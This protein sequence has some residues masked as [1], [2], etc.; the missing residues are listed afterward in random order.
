MTRTFCCS[1]M[2][3]LAGIFSNACTLFD[4]RVDMK[5]VLVSKPTSQ[6]RFTIRVDAPGIAEARLVID[7]IELSGRVTVGASIPL[8]LSSWG[9]GSHR[10]EAR[11]YDGESRRDS[12]T[13]VLVVDRTPPTATAAPAPGDAYV[14]PGQPFIVELTFSDEIEPATVTPAAV[15][16]TQSN[17]A[18]PVPVT[19]SLS[20]D[21]RHLRIEG[22][23]LADLQAVDL[24][25]SVTNAAGLDGSMGFS[26]NYR[27]VDVTLL[28]PG[29]SSSPMEYAGVI[30][31]VATWWNPGQV[32]SVEVLVDGSPIGSMEA[33]VPF[34]WDTNSVA[35]GTHQITF[36][37]DG[38]ASRP[39]DLFVRNLGPLL[40]SC[41]PN[42]A[43]GLDPAGAADF[44]IA[45]DQPVCLGEASGGV[46]TGP[47]AGIGIA[48]RAGS[49]NFID[50]YSSIWSWSPGAASSGTHTVSFASARN[51]TG[52][53]PRGVVECTMTVPKWRAPFGDT[54][55]AQLDGAD[56]VL[57]DWEGNGYFGLSGISLVRI[58]PGG[59]STPGA[60]EVWR[61]SLDANWWQD[62]SA[63]NGEPFLPA[64]Q[65]R[66]SK[67]TATWIE[68]QPDGGGRIRSAKI[69]W[70]DN[71]LQPAGTLLTF[72]AAAGPVEL[73]ASG[74]AWSQPGTAGARTLFVAVGFGLIADWFIVPV[75]VDSLAD[76]SQGWYHPQGYVTYIETPSGGVGQL[77]VRKLTGRIPAG[78]NSLGDVLNRD[79]RTEPSEPSV[80]LA[81]LQGTL[82]PVVTWVEGGQVLVRTWMEPGGW[83]PARML[84]TDPGKVA[85]SPRAFED[86][87]GGAHLLFV[88]RGV[89][90]DRIEFRSFD[91]T[92]WSVDDSLHP[93]GDV[94]EVS[95]AIISNQTAV[96]WRNPAGTARLRVSRW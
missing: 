29:P 8:D 93:F 78:W 27:P 75:N 26:W 94:S 3:S 53:A 23:P 1:L 13:L 61:N 77:R 7:D 22:P 76:A 50:W 34:L 11:F 39:V 95:T 32:Q 67:D 63:L 79:P 70:R 45:F 33:D 60:V 42:V 89:D 4:S 91:G 73:A 47:F 59:S 36:L 20:A 25:A 49:E 62:G 48:G 46:C 28:K 2:L 19:L 86:L 83:T 80:S 18:S 81:H 12:A 40:V 90:G 85:R 30:E 43:T 58:T 16:V 66:A 65:L 52:M 84:N 51:R 15:Q 69:S 37:A 24:V 82:V 68:S 6:G 87:F 57:L 92:T 71:Q 9:D 96:L 38:V 74:S 55:P 31:L 10:V 17:G 14:P 64:T 88:E 54:L 41:T 21:H 5:L 72:P 56:Q 44:L 35:D